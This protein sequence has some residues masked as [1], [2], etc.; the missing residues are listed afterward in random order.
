MALSPQEF[1]KLRLRLAGLKTR[2]ENVPDV[3]SGFTGSQGAGVKD[4]LAGV[5]FK[6]ADRISSAI[7]GTGE[8][9]D[10]SLLRRGVGATTA[11]FSSVPA[12]A[13]ALAPEPVRRGVEVV[14]EVMG[15]GFG[16]LTDTIAS[17]K[18]FSEIGNLEAQGLI[19]PKDNPEFFAL[20][21]ALATTGETGEIAGNIAGAAG[22]VKTMGAVNTGVRTAASAVIPPIKGATNAVVG[23]VGAVARPVLEGAKNIPSRIGTNIKAV[24]VTEQAIKALPEVAQKS[25]RQGVDIDDISKVLTTNAVQK[26][27]LSK[28]YTLT[29]DF[30]SGKNKNNPIEAVGKPVVKRFDTLKGQTAK[31]GNQLDDVAEGLVGKEVKGRD[32]IIVSVDETLAKLRISKIDDGIDFKGSN[33]EGL[34]ANEKIISNIYKRLQESVDANDLH[35]LKKYI[36]NNVDFGKTSGGFT[37]EAESL[38]KG[39]RKIIDDTLDTEFPNYNK[40]N[41]ELALRLK[42]INDFKR[43]MGQITGLDEDLMNMSAGMLMRRIA[44]NVRSNPQLRQVLRDLDNATKVKGKLS[45]NIEGLVDFYSTL[46]KYF[47][48]I[49]GKNTFKGQIKGALEESGGVLDRVINIAKGVAGQ[50]EAVKRKAITDFLDDFFKK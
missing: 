2:G 7:Q 50:S 45:L 35:R 21:D 28:L 38:I 29:K 24:Q 39:W 18:L 49:V 19:N 9:Q 48:E 3:P 30:V 37:G 25:V 46:E 31:L 22:A 34:G 8:Y 17:T 1:E 12:G 4:R 32:L 11:A 26:P 41:K 14:G 6:T 16:F 27:A 20:K 47:P 13:L 33:L 10:S 15:K 43:I 40:V 42:P 44:S 5:G 36:D 23:A